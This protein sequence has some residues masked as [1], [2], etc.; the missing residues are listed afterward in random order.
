[1]ATPAPWKSRLEWDRIALD[2][3]RGMRRVPERQPRLQTASLHD[4]WPGGISTA[5]VPLQK[6]PDDP[7]CRE[8][9]RYL[10]S[11]YLDARVYEQRQ[12]QC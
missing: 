11:T 10:D 12:W 9:P 2:R 7:V 1:M 4:G 5:I 3:Q 6:S 8:E